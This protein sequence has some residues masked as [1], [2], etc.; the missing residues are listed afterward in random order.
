[1]SYQKKVI[2]L[3]SIAELANPLQIHERFHLE[4]EKVSYAQKNIRKVKTDK[5]HTTIIS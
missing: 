3:A 4:D 5:R 1:M 2:P